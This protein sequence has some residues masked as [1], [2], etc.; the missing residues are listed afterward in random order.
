M[1]EVNQEALR[2]LCSGPIT[3]Q[4]I[5]EISDATVRMTTSVDRVWK[6]QAKLC[7]PYADSTSSTEDETLGT[8]G[9]I[10][11]LVMEGSVPTLP[12]LSTLVYLQRAKCRP[13]PASRLPRCRPLIFLAAL[14]LAIRSTKTSCWQ[15][16]STDAGTLFSQAEVDLAVKYLVYWLGGDLDI[17][18]QGLICALDAYLEPIR[19]TIVHQ[20][21]PLLKREETSLRSPATPQNDAHQPHQEHPVSPTRTVHGGRGCRRADAEEGRPCHTINNTG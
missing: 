19:R 18:E 4:I 15:V 16:W 2:R 12:L 13:P 17:E 20:R 6:P 11:R 7:Q 8:E 14:I 9:Y 5:R 3:R 1:D 21:H 10:H